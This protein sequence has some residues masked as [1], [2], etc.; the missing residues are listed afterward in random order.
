MSAIHRPR[1]RWSVLV[2]VML[3]AL[4][5]ASTPTAT[6]AFFLLAGYA[7]T[8][9]AQAIQALALSWLFSMLSPGIAPEVPQAALGRYAVIAGAALSVLLRARRGRWSSGAS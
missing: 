4:R 3:L 2:V 1:L 8:G 7:L 9:R 5:L 6:A